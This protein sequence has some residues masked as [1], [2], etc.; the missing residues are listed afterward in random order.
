MKFKKFLSGILVCATVCSIVPYVNYAVNANAVDETEYQEGIYEILTYKKYADYIEISGCTQQFYFGDFDDFDGSV[1]IPAEID[2]LP[3]T[4]IGERALGNDFLTSVTIPDS[5]TEIGKYTFSNCSSLAS[6]KIP[7]SVTSIGDYAFKGSGLK[8]VIIP[9]GVTKIGEYAFQS[10]SELTEITLPDSITDIGIFAFSDCSSLKSVTIPEG[11]TKI[12]KYTFDNCSDLAEIN[13]SD[14]VTTIVGNAFS[15]CPSLTEVNIPDSVTSIDIFAFGDCSG[16]NAINV[17]DN[18]KYYSSENGILFNKDK[19]ELLQCPIGNPSEKYTIPESVESIGI[20][21]FYN[22]MNLEEVEIPDNVTNIENYSFINCENLY[23]ITIENPKCKIYN[24]RN[25]ISDKA[26]IYGYKD[27]TA[28][29]YAEKYDRK[30]VALDLNGDANGDREVDVA[31]VIA[32]ASYVANPEENPLPEQLIKNA[33]VH[34][35]GD[36]LT[37]NDALMIQQYLAGI[38]EKL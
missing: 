1:V 31:D 28:N 16:L 10:C 13:I 12:E 25:A 5:V 3:V 38:V 14:N 18:N 7:D 26:T 29:K 36:G 24:G 37:A 20:F 17:S 11:I 33:D 8:S 21:A 22:C 4:K 32:V 34:N 30:F 27:S 23:K 15:R 6:I 9:D 35:S 19:T 2:G